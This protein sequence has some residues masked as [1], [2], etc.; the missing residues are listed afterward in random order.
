MVASH[1]R[2]VD[3]ASARLALASS[4]DARHG[5]IRDVGCAKLTDIPADGLVV[6]PAVQGEGGSHF[7][8]YE[9]QCA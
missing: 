5:V 1:G 8:I 2:W 9:G 7:K 4:K 6:E 3:A